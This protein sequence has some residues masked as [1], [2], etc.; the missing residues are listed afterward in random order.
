MRVIGGVIPFLKSV[1]LANLVA[2]PWVEV[3]ELGRA[4]ARYA[5]RL[6][7]S[8]CFAEP[9][10]LTLCALPLGFSV[11]MPTSTESGLIDMAT[12]IKLGKQ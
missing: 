6:A 8:L 2:V 10:A 4:A 1:P 12:I 11:A 7:I 9:A 5:S 3:N